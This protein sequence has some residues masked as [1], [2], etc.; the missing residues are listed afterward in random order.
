MRGIVH[1]LIL[2]IAAAMLVAW[3][4]GQ[5]ATVQATLSPIPF[6]SI[7]RRIATPTPT[8]IRPT[9]TPAWPTPTR[10]TEFIPDPTVLPPT[11]VWLVPPPT[12][13]PFEDIVWDPICPPFG[14]PCDWIGGS[15]RCICFCDAAMWCQD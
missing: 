14:F 10:I 8:P 5:T 6:E 13:V 7:V 2:G 1:I 3:M 4:M 12:P 15:E 9:L 11:P